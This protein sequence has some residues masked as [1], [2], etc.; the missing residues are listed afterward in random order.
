VAPRRQGNSFCFE[1]NSLEGAR[2]VVQAKMALADTN[3]VD[4]SGTIT[5]TAPVTTYCVPLTSPYHFF[6]VIEGLA[7]APAPPV[8][9]AIT[10]IVSGPGGVTLSWQA[11]TNTQWRV[12]WTPLLFPPNWV[13]FTNVIT[14]A[15]GQFNFTDN[16][17]QSGGP[18]STRYYRLLSVP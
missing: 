4:H 7:L 10:N 6:R 17:S 2:Y 1:W 14:S 13:S 18:G 15:S 9:V 5:A 16:G 8:P 11:E 3:W 12:Q